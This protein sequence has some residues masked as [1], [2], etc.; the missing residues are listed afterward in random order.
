MLRN[1]R[2][3]SF[4]WGFWSGRRHCP[5]FNR[6]IKRSL[7]RILELV[8]I[9]R[10]VPCYSTVESFLVQSFLLWPLL[11]PSC[12]RTTLVRFTFLNDA[13]RWTRSFLN[14][15][16]V[17]RALG[18][19][20][21]EIWS[22]I[23][24]FPQNRLSPRVI[25]GHT[26][27]LYSLLHQS[28]WSFRTTFLSLFAVR[29]QTCPFIWPLHKSPCA[30]SW[31]YMSL[32]WNIVHV[33]FTEHTLPLSF[34]RRLSV[35]FDSWWLILSP[36]LRS[37]LWSFEFSSSD[38]DEVLQMFSILKNSHVHYFEWFLGRTK[39][40]RSEAEQNLVISTRTILPGSHNRAWSHRTSKSWTSSFCER[41]LN[42]SECS[43]AASWAPVARKC[44]Q[45]M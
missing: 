40:R 45:I 34:L 20:D 6:S 11:K 27:Q 28:N 30:S 9:F 18:E 17:P 25:F 2:E 21:G 13:S 24:N 7:V 8:N 38:Q 41:I 15:Y 29:S 10:Q 43:C 39:P 33:L 36:Q 22:Q 1:Q 44:S 35:L 4:L 31:N 16:V 5:W 26:T 42:K 32:L 19:F 12:A 37:G 23:W 3:C 14:F